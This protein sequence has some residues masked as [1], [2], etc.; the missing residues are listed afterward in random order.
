MAKHKLNTA[1]LNRL[2][3]F[4]YG[5]DV[6]V[7]SVFVTILIYWCVYSFVLIVLLVIRFFWLCIKNVNSFS[8]DQCWMA[9]TVVQW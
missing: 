9:G 6:I 1:I 8:D 5:C 3:V 7:L 2:R 4:M